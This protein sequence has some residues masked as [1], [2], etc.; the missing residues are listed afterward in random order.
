MKVDWALITNNNLK[1]T[2]VIN[3][4]LRPQKTPKKTR[5]NLCNTPTLA[6]LIY[7]SGNSTIKARDA[8]RI[9]TVEM[10]YMRKTE[11]YTWTDYRTN[12]EFVKEINVTPVLDTIHEYMGN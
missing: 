5:I 6:A 1:V 9:T 10:K 3:N 2:G 12:T 7:G 11:G 8:R 4:V